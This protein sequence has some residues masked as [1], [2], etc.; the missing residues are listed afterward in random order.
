MVVR[1]KESES[2]LNKA[3]DKPK[4]YWWDKAKRSTFIL[5]KLRTAK[6][7]S[8]IMERFPE[9]NSLG[10]HIVLITTRDIYEQLIADKSLVPSLSGIKGAYWCKGYGVMYAETD[11]KN[12]KMHKEVL[13]SVQELIEDLRQDKGPQHVYAFED[14]KLVYEHSD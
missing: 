9:A 7:F 10:D 13:E 11:F 12:K 1:K 4:A 3:E 6:N 5:I 8:K 2:I 14:E